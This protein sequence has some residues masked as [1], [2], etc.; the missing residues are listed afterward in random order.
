MKTACLYSTLLAGCVLGASAQAQSEVSVYGIVDAALVSERGGAAGNVNKLTSG[1]SAYSRLGFRGKE[2]LGDGWSAIFLLE[3][4]MRIDDGSLDN[5]NGQLF[6]R[7]AYIGLESRDWGAVRLGRQHTFLY[8]TLVQVADP[9]S[10]GYA[11]TAKNLFP[12]KNTV[13]SSNTVS[14]TSPTRRGWTG[15]ASYSLGEQPGDAHAGRQL[16]LAIGY[17]DGPLTVRFAHSTLNQDVAA[18]AVP[19]AA[20]VSQDNARNSVLAMNYRYALFTAYLAYGVDKGVNSSPVPNPGAYGVASAVVPSTDSTDLLLGAAIPV[21]QQGRVMASFIR[22]N[23]KT[24]FQQDASQWAIGYAHGLSPRTTAYLAWAKIHNRNGAAYT[25]GN[26]NEAG[27]GNSAFNLG[28]RH[29][30]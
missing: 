5:T 29:N 24:R 14:Y 6:N 23:D 26:G 12:V 28:L 2:D 3:M 16:G 27:S 1:T 4:G 11:G 25:V 17:A 9:F 7:Q 13:R 15:E 30:F 8:Y 21:G 18:G 10:L 19:L 22:K 20:P